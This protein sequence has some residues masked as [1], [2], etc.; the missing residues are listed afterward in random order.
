MAAYRM[1]PGRDDG[2]AL[3]EVPEQLLVAAVDAYSVAAGP[4]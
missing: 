3:L 1:F 2:G 4:T